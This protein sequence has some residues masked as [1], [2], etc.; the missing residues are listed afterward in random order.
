MESPRDDLATVPALAEDLVD[1]DPEVRDRAGLALWRIEARSPE[2]LPVAELLRPLAR[3]APA[4]WPGRHLPL[5]PGDLDH[6]F[7]DRGGGE[8]YHPFRNAPTTAPA[9]GVVYLPAAPRRDDFLTLLRLLGVDDGERTEYAAFAAAA[10][11]PQR[12][13]YLVQI[14]TITP[15]RLERW[16]GARGDPA[17]LRQERPLA[18]L[19]WAFVG[20][21][22]AMW[23]TAAADPRAPA[24]A[25]GGDHGAGREELAFGFMV[26]GPGIYR[27]W[28]RACLSAKPGPA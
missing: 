14:R 11:D 6:F 27:L 28:S 15:W 12:D 1:P 3:L 25:L 19:L 13:R 18:E 9:G 8:D 23:G 2:P 17:L 16:F 26:E 24:G 22:Q 21:Q 10:E 5:Q 20:H 7:T 4:V